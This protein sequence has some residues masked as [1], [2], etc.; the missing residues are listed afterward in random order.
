MWIIP[1]NRTTVSAPNQPLLT[2]AQWRTVA[3]LLPRVRPT[4]RGGRPRADA[5]ACLEGILWVLRNGRRWRDLP[6][7]FPSPATCWRR[8]NDWEKAG[9]WLFVWR[10]YQATLEPDDR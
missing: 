2:D 8:L 7:H 3:A 9:V 5:R 4:P 6:D 1:A 10:A